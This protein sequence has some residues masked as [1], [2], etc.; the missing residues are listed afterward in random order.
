MAL[1]QLS[2]IGTSMGLIQ[3]KQIAG[4]LAGVPLLPY[5]QGQFNRD[6]GALVSCQ[7]AANRLAIVGGD[8]MRR[9]DRGTGDGNNFFV[10]P[11]RINYLLRS[12]DFASG[13]SVA[14]GA[15]LGLQATLGPDA[16]VAHL[17]SQLTFG[18][19][20]VSNLSQA[21]AAGLVPINQSIVFSVWVK[22]SSGN[23]L[24]KLQITNTSGTTTT[25]ANFTAGNFW[26][27]YS[28]VA[29]SGGS[30]ATPMTVR[31][32]NGDASVHAIFIAFSQLE[33]STEMTSTILN[34][35]STGRGISAPDVL[36]FLPGQVPTQYHSGR[37]TG[38]AFAS[39]S[40]AN[41]VANGNRFVIRSFDD[42][43]TLE[44]TSDGAN[45]Q[46][47]ARAGGVTRA[48]S[49]NL[50]LAEYAACAYIVD[51]A[52]GLLTVNGVVGPAG[53]PWNWKSV[54]EAK[55]VRIGGVL[56]GASGAEFMGELDQEYAA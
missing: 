48:A 14:S 13:W 15:V 5:Y 39:R 38:R 9:Q 55:G 34:D 43:N 54:A 52:A 18:A 2:Q 6:Q 27:R 49:Q 7:T 23:G 47:I 22:N 36:Q 32:V 12:G 17:A 53:T 44:L 1:I 26:Q 29:N 3:P 24:F 56:G 21:C 28:F 46:L 4:F 42:V 10:E 25:S 30:A 40:T 8:I 50:T 51:P 19:S 20:A 45:V 35:L 31:I 33:T 11:Q 37:S 16:Y 41:M